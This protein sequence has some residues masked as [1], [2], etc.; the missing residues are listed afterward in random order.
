MK[1]SLILVFFIFNANTIFSQQKNCFDIARK[2]TLNEIITEYNSN[3][4]VIDSVDTN[5]T[6]MLIL[7]CYRGNEDVAKFMVQKKAN[8]DYVSGNGTALMSCIVKGNF[9]MADILLKNK[10]NPNLA[11]ANGITALM[12]A[13]QF[14]NEKMVKLLLENKADKSIADK[15]G[16]TAFEYA[17]FSKN[18]LITNLLK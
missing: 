16:K 2:G 6:S 14:Q 17:V 9:E 15:Q 10:A 1:C 12:Y 11:D 7:A 18:E 3:N 4:K 8:L 13:V 5:S